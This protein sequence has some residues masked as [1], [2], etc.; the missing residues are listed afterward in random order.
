MARGGAQKAQCTYRYMSISSTARVPDGKR[1]KI[2]NRFLVPLTVLLR[3]M[4]GWP[5]RSATDHRA[6]RRTDVPR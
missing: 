4:L 6:F 1:S 5:E 2:L 3:L